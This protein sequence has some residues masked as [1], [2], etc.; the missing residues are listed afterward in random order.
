MG[1]LSKKPYKQPI[2]S[3]NCYFYKMNIPQY[4]FT[5]KLFF[6]AIVL[7]T[8]LPQIIF[9]Q[10][11]APVLTAT[12]SQVYCPGSPMNIVTGF[13][14][15]DPDDTSIEAVYI[16]ISEGY[17]NGQDFL[18]L[19]GTHPGI[20]TSWNAVA[21]KLT[22]SGT[23]GD[24]VPYTDLIAAV[25]DVM[26]NNTA[27][28]PT[29]GT[30]TFSITI[31]QANYLPSTGHYYMFVP[32]INI[33]WTAAKAAAET[34]TYYGLQGY[35]VTIT[36]ADEAQLCGEQATGTGWIGGNDAGAEGV[37]KWVT[38]PEAGITFWNGNFTGST[39]NYAF[40]NNSEPNDTGGNEDYAHITAPGVGIPGSW[41]D[42]PN[43]GGTGDYQAMGYIVE[44]GG[45]PGDPVLQISAS[46]TIEVRKLISTTPASR[47]GEGTV[48]LEAVSTG[49]LVYWYAD[50]TGGSPI[51]TGSGFTTPPISATTTYYASAFN[52][53]CNA[54]RTAVIAT[55]NEIPTLTIAQPTPVCSGEAVT[56][57]ATPSAGT[58]TWYTTATEGT[59]IGTGNTFTTPPLTEDTTFYAEAVD[60]GCVSDEREAV[61]VIL[62]EKP[63][64]EDEIISFCENSITTLHA[65]MPDATYEWST[66]E[67]TP[68]IDVSE[69]GAY[70]V[71]ITNTSGCSAGKT[72]T[73]QTLPAP[74][75]VSVNV[76]NTT[77]SVIMADGGINEYSLDGVAWQDSNIFTGLSPGAYTVRAR[78]VIGCGSDTENF[79]IYIIPKFFTPNGDSVN[80]VFTI[81]GMLHLPQAKVSIFDRYGKLITYLNHIKR[82]WDGTLNG[83]L[84]PATDY[85]YIIEID[86]TTPEIK[87]HFSLIR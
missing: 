61:T 24:G 32:N 47:C 27:I 49:A 81:A 19:T 54:P 70:T 87:G 45:M 48:I 13:T 80:D 75:I 86:N 73:L 23:G 76:I 64:V 16:Q 46:T 66:G 65:G 58:I 59:P 68:T 35:L 7:F 2:A 82:S 63:D 4:S 57:E 6:I 37:W 9:A 18:T 3:F 79:V 50:A 11:E 44:Y 77:A 53:D 1:Y 22:I 62:L 26:Y 10:N 34:S 43:I 20:T 5:A 72:F 21:G 12:G 14:I 56:L 8:A 25:E 42:L 38:G 85:W 74:D 39:P 28:D 51:S 67:T 29:A 17:V 55:V 69:A 15:T 52:E 60:N 33:T 84:L 41:N 83:E 30:R 36:S 31:G 71:T 78:S 40:W